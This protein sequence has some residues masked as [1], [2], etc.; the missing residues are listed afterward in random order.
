MIKNFMTNHLKIIKIVLIIIVSPIIVYIITSFM[1][2]IF[3]IG[4][5]VG[6]F[7]RSVYTYFVC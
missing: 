6:T 2:I 4:N 7:L 5:Y 3:T 1:N